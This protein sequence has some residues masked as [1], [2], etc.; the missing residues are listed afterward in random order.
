MSQDGP[1]AFVWMKEG[2]DACLDNFPRLLPV[3]LAFQVAAVMPALLI[4]KYSENR[5]YA[6]PWELF[7]GAP[8]TIGMN[9]FFI[10]L[11]RTGRAD[12]GDF[13][14][15]FSVFPQAVAV[16][17][18]YGLIVTGGLIM[19]IIPG[20]VWGLAYVFAQ[21]AVVDK[22][23]GIKGSFK[24]SS[25]ITGGFK[26]RLFP[27]AMLWVTLEV[28]T[29]GIVTAEGTILQMR[30]ALDLKPWVLTA[31]ILKTLV[32][33]PWLNMAL[34][35]AYISLVKHHDREARL[36]HRSGIELPAG[37]PL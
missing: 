26:E 14:R 8:L 15:G 31:F 23:T 3:V 32:F 33:L 9:L 28:L 10:N 35:Q 4:W 18:L 22:K 6:M 12:Y 24:Y 11:A 36:N 7:V 5:W 37:N 19:L 29:P 1:P 20:I 17:F 16:S 13:F 27:L 21:Y 34:A 30:L 2:W 25:L